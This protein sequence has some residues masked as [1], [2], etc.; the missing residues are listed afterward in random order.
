MFQIR[1]IMGAEP[2]QGTVRFGPFRLDLGLR[3]LSRD[4]RR[5]KLGSRAVEILCTLAAAGGE[6]VTKD[7]IIE[8]RA[9]GGGE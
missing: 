4:G 5:I 3:Q 9:C 7:E 1:S 8:H 2:L 6:I